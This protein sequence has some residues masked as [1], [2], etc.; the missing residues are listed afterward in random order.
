[1]D[2]KALFVERSNLYR[3]LDNGKFDADKWYELAQRFEDIGWANNA[4]KLR[5]K[6]NHYAEKWTVME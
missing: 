4:E 6:A 2:N 1:M 3:E 5:K